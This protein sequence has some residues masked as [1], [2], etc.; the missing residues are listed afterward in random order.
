MEESRP[1]NKNGQSPDVGSTGMAHIKS[2]TLA[3]AQRHLRRMRRRRHRRY[4][5]LSACQYN[6]QRTP[7]QWNGGEALEVTKW[8]TRSTPRVR[9]RSAQTTRLVWCTH[10]TPG[11]EWKSPYRP[12]DLR[13]RSGRAD[14]PPKPSRAGDC[15][16]SPPVYMWGTGD[17][18]VTRTTTPLP[19]GSRRQDLGLCWARICRSMI[20]RN[21]DIQGSRDALGRSAIMF[22]LR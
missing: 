4:S 8:A 22:G 2:S 16:L 20:V 10:R 5:G 21:D 19:P 3:A 18:T 15:D 7:S 6:P 1:T 13:G 14:L 12:R 11:P 17:S 9:S